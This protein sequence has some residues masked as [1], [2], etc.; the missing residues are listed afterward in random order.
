MKI[1]IIACFL[2]AVTAQDEKVNLDE[3]KACVKNF[4][5]GENLTASCESIMQLL[6]KDY[7]ARASRNIKSNLT[8]TCAKENFKE[9]KIS[10]FMLH[11]EFVE[12]LED[13]IVIDQEQQISSTLAELCERLEKFDKFYEGERAQLKSQSIEM[14]SKPKYQCLYKYFVGKKMIDTSNFGFD[15]SDFDSINCTDYFADSDENFKKPTAHDVHLAT[16]FDE[17]IYRKKATT[18]LHSER[19][20]LIAI[21]MFDLSEV[22]EEKYRAMFLRLASASSRFALE[23]ARDVYTKK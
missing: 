23:C 22:Q 21:A 16:K 10:D 14:R 15:T 13:S 19:A 12:E 1:L 3:M 5:K 9:Y 20:I 7:F 17:C 4:V 11:I 2:A 8:L 6:E 18:E